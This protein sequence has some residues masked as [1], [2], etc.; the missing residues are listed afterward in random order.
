M[1]W[2]SP[3]RVD[4]KSIL[5]HVVKRV[6]LSGKPFQECKRVRSF[7]KNFSLLRAQ[8]CLT[9]L[10]PICGFSSQCVRFQCSQSDMWGW[11]HQP[12]SFFQQTSI[13]PITHRVCSCTQL[14]LLVFYFIIIIILGGRPNG[15]C[16]LSS[17]ARD[18]TCASC[19]GN[20]E[21]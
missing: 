3:Q 11:P 8:Q 20:T 15:M 19:S 21:F 17:S 5:N 9:H 4:S 1:V 2:E 14:A 16:N 10:K 13:H 6:V 18:W 7:L 12:R